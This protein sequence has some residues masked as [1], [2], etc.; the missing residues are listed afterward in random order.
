M[1]CGK[2]VARGGGGGPQKKGAVIL[3]YRVAECS[4]P[5]TY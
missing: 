1:V 3:V 4:I 2:E 5:G